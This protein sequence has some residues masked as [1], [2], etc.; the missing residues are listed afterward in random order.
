[1][2]RKGGED[3]HIKIRVS[4]TESMSKQEAVRRLRTTIKTRIVQEG[5]ELHWLDWSAPE[6]KGSA[7]YGS[8]LEDEAHDALVNFYYALTAPNRRLRIA[9]VDDEGEETEVLSDE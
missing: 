7:N 1:M 9:V 2:P 4:L 6:R 5:I 8:Y 3:I